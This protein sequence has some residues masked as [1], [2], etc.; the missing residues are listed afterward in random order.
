MRPERTTKVA[1]LPN[2]RVVTRCCSRL[3]RR[4]RRPQLIGL[5]V[6]HL[7]RRATASLRRGG[8]DADWNAIE[9]NVLLAVT[10]SIFAH[11]MTILAIDER[12][13]R[14][15][16]TSRSNQLGNP[17]TLAVVAIRRLR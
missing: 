5:D 7:V 6:V 16:L 4:P 8:H 9:I 17:L 1:P 3:N 14:L 12:R 2:N 11:E 10:A 15:Q 13:R